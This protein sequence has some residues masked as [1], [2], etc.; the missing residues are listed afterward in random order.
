[1][2]SQIHDMCSKCSV[3][4]EHRKSNAKEPLKPHPAPN[5][6]WSKVGTDLFHLGAKMYLIVVD[7]YSKFPE[8]MLLENTMSQGVINAMKSIFSRHGI[9]DQ[10]VSD[11]G[12]QYSSYKFG[13]FATKWQFEHIMSSPRFPQSNG[14]AERTI[15][16][17]KSMLRKAI[18]SNQDPYLSLLEYR[19]TPIDKDLGSP[20]QLLMSRRTKTTLPTNPKLLEP[21]IR[22]NIQK[23]LIKRQNVQ[24]KYYDQNTTKLP[25]L[26]EGDRVSNQKVTPTKVICC[27]NQ[28]RRSK[29]K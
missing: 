6:A 4:L 25:E 11:G 26:S 2:S 3:C 17:V 10:V 23:D 27:A 24:K 21:E 16:T 7:Y 13:E 22:Q 1:M 9:P 19:N 20:C 12:P 28:R 14:M 15:Q 8:V 5:R 18:K 29:K